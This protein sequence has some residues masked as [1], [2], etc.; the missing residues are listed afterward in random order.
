MDTKPDKKPRLMLVLRTGIR[1]FL[2]ENEVIKMI[3]KNGFELVTV[4]PKRTDNITEFSKVV[5]SCDVLMGVHGDIRTR[6]NSTVFFVLP[7]NETFSK[8]H[9]WTFSPYSDKVFGSKQVTVKQLR[10]NQ[11]GPICTIRSDIPAVIFALR[12][13]NLWHYI[14]DIIIP[15]FLAAKPYNDLPYKIDPRPDKKPRLML[16]LRAGIR[17]FLNEPE[18]VEIVKKNGFELVLVEPQKTV[19]LTEFSKLVDSCDVLMGVH[20]AALTNILFL[21]TNALLIQIIPYGH[22]DNFAFWYYGRQAQE[23]KIREVHYTISPEESSL[24]EKY[25]RDHPVIKDPDSVNARGFED[26]MKYYWYEQDVRLN[27]TRFE[28]VLV[29]ALELLKE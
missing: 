27:V 26:R 24:L 17:R 22:I 10:A 20:G 21:R 25:G 11:D 7:S 16:V 6:A 12:G 1:K 4:E 19:N 3:K 14:S 28:P 15:L 23:M 18:V 13:Q 5:D 2:N 8:E 29:K 9:E